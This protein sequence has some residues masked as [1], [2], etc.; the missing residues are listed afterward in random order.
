MSYVNRWKYHVSSR[1]MDEISQQPINFESMDDEKAIAVFV[2]LH[3]DLNVCNSLG[4]YEHTNDWD[5]YIE[6][7]TFDDDKFES[8][9]GYFQFDISDIESRGY[10]EKTDEFEVWMPTNETET[11]DDKYVFLLSDIKEIKVYR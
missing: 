7:T 6:I 11:G 1:L 4:D 10:P 5:P 8:A 3:W 9:P 2:K